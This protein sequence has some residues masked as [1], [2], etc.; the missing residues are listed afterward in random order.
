MSIA[1]SATAKKMLR[2][3][4]INGPSRTYCAN[5][6]P[7]VIRTVNDTMPADTKT[8]QTFQ[9]PFERFAAVG[10]VENVC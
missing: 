4:F 5:F 10:V 1:V 3:L 8:P 9:L 6:I 7:C 2:R